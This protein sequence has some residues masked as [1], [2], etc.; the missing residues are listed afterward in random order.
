MGGYILAGWSNFPNDE[1]YNDGWLIKTDAQGKE[2][3]SHNFGDSKDDLIHSIAE[4]GDG[5]YI[6]VGETISPVNGSYDGW[7][8][9]LNPDGQVLWSKSF[10][11]DLQDVFFSVSTTKD[12]GYIIA[13]QTQLSDATDFDGWL[14]KVS[15]EGQ[16]VWSRTYDTSIGDTL[17]KALE[18]VDGG[19]ILA[20]CTGTKDSSGFPC[21]DDGWVIK[22]D[23]QG[24]EVWSYTFGGKNPD[25]FNFVA[26]TDDGGYVLSGWASST[27][28]GEPTGWLLKLNDKE[29]AR[30]KN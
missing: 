3:W 22:T 15:S 29:E 11:G 20:G 13:G 7:L 16:E 30:E 17:Y 1:R 2:I 27:K 6:L 21:I 26:Q 8:I 5:G 9:K 10:G 14:L 12:G 25:A 18:T 24:Q 4:T 23:G 28:T 19:F